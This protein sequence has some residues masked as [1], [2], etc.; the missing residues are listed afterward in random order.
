MPARKTLFFFLAWL[1][2][3]PLVWSADRSYVMRRI[4]GEQGLSESHVYAILQ[5][6]MGFMWVGTRDGLNRYD[7]FGFVT[8]RHDPDNIH[9]ISNNFIYAIF[10]SSDGFL[11]IGTRAGLNRFDRKRGEFYAFRHDPNEDN[12]LG[13]DIIWS[14]APEPGSKD[15]VLWL[16]TNT[17]LDRFDMD[18]GDFSHYRADPN[19]TQSLKPGPV[20]GLAIEPGGV[21]WATTNGGGL[22]RMLLA[23]PGNFQHYGIEQGLPGLLGT[24]LYLDENTLWISSND[25]LS[26]LNTARPNERVQPV[27]LSAE[28]GVWCVLPDK[29]QGLWVAT[30]GMGLHRLGPGKGKQR[31]WRHDPEDQRT[32]GHDEIWS[33][34]LDR[35]GNI[36]IGT[37]GGGLTLAV[38]TAFG[39]ERPGMERAEVQA[40][41]R[42][43]QGGLWLGRASSGLAWYPPES[44]T[45][46]VYRADTNN[47]DSLADDGVTALLEDRQG[48]I[49]VGTRRGLLDRFDPDTGRFSH[50]VPK[51]VLAQIGSLFQDADSR[52]WIGTWN[53][54]YSSDSQMSQKLIGYWHDSTN[55]AS[56]DGNVVI[57]IHG[58]PQNREKPL[59][60]GT[61]NN[62]LHRMSLDRPGHFD[63]FRLRPGGLSSDAIFSIYETEA[64]LLWLGT[65]NGLNLLDPNT[66]EA[67]SY[68]VKQGLISNTVYHILPGRAD[69]L[70]LSTPK[71]LSRFD[72]KTQTFRNF[73]RAHGLKVVDFSRG[74]GLRLPDGQLVFGGIGGLIG[75]DPNHVPTAAPTIPAVLTELQVDNHI[76]QVAPD[77][78]DSLLP[79]PLETTTSLQLSYENRSLEIHFTALDYAAPEANRYRYQLVGFNQDWV[80]TDSEFRRATYTNLDPD[81]YYFHLQ[82]ARKGG[83]WGPLRQMRVVVPR[84]PWQSGWAYT[85][86]IALVV[87]LISWYL[88]LQRQRLAQEQRV[89]KEMRRLDGLKDE[90]LAN[91]SHE[92]RTPL[93]GM[94]GL[95]ESLLDGG[96]HFS[97]HTRTNLAMIVN[98]GRR[99]NSLINDILDFSKLK[100][101]ELG[102]N[103]VAID[104]RAVVDLVL[105]LTRTL[106]DAKGLVLENRV[107]KDLPP[108]LADEDRLQQIL[109]NLIGNAVKFTESGE[110]LISAKQESESI[111][112]RVADTGPGIKA[113]DLKRIF[114]SFE[115]ADSGATR[116]HGGTGLGL[117]ICSRLVML[118]GGHIQVESQPGEGSTFSFDLPVADGKQEHPAS[119]VVPE[120]IPKAVLEVPALPVLTRG[121]KAPQTGPAPEG[122][123]HLL[124]VDDEP[125]NL[126]VL[127]N[128]LAR[129]RTTLANSGS[130]ALTLLEAGSFDLVVL[131]VMMPGQTGY[132]VCR[133]IRETYP[134]HELPVLFLTART[135]TDDLISGFLAGGNDYLGKPIAARELSHRVGIQLRLLQA[136]RQLATKNEEI[137]LKEQQK[138]HAVKTLTEAS[139]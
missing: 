32:P 109:L 45:P 74:C 17:G 130:E 7:G 9:S 68:H 98:S 77:K 1:A 8:Y 93:H 128:H 108:V 20:F 94:I 139:S 95:A 72:R 27:K 88:Y 59:W 129:H 96:R 42:D 12:S 67:D 136:G 134:V 3:L 84:P 85:L 44:D 86:Y 57:T 69:G 19:D 127:Q 51:N 133:I 11:W 5:D 124:L 52:L 120:T 55:A 104:L 43:R 125:V 103:R 118:H 119:E 50:K 87:G 10:E 33:L 54:L 75:F 31:S 115:Q 89:V 113:E 26:R 121:E 29:E 13:H 18:T 100:N 24:K 80:E 90:F 82:A 47:P 60:I 97:E 114:L 123:F 111:L 36:W 14:L 110:V 22:H 63:H 25:G 78:A 99:L 116:A 39:M 56:L 65:A 91:T 92:L 73:D 53:G 122:G 106:A 101:G 4:T 107:P 117:A 132:E 64:G 66:G 48:K 126:Q 23:E 6:S 37:Y 105:L 30:Q 71:G 40:V 83:P 102:L 61:F 137:K 28:V 81:V 138:M 34:A 41:L 70:W 35:G 79:Q 135:R 46:M 112:I 15:R 2:C 21:L 38:P 58:D 16:A 49:W 76:V 62:G 131:D